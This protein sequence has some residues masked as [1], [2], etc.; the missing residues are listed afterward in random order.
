MDKINKTANLIKVAV[1][2]DYNICN[3]LLQK[4]QAHA[5]LSGKIK[6]I[7]NL[8]KVHITQIIIGAVGTF[9]NKFND[10]ISKVAL[11]NHKFQAKEAEKIALLGTAH[12]V[13]SF[14]R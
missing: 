1:P 5:D 4:I 3:K 10:Y 9:Y 14:Y 11:T 6:T 12:I 8:N 13:R 7:W 2:N